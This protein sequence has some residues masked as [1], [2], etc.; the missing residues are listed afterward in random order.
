MKLFRKL[1]L[2]WNNVEK[3]SR[4]GQATDNNMER[5]NCMLDAQGYKHALRICNI[6]CFSTATVVTR[7]RKSSQQNPCWETDGFSPSQEI[8]YT[9]GNQK[10]I[11]LFW[12]ARHWT[13]SR[14]R[15]IQYI[16]SQLPLPYKH[17]K[18]Q[19]SLCTIHEATCGSIGSASLILNLGNIHVVV[20]DHLYAAAVITPSKSSSYMLNTRLTACDLRPSGTFGEGKISCLCQE[21]NTIRRFVSPQPAANTGSRC[22]RKPM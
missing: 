8:P 21:S 17:V 6:P 22:A 7:T 18:V 16:P 15:R 11:T 19:L 13:L 10:L 5:A 20:S 12:K 1:Y 9:Y 3:Y 14:A 2:L 4:A